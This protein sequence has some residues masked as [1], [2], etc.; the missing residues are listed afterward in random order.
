MKKF[1]LLTVV[2][3]IAGLSGLAFAFGPGPGD[4]DMRQGHGGGRYRDAMFEQALNLTEEQI[5]SVKQIRQDY[6]EQLRS[7]NDPA[8][9]GALMGLDPSDPAYSEQVEEIAKIRAAT[10]EEEI[11]LRAEKHAKIFAV[12]D[13][14]QREQFK[15]L[16]LQRKQ[17][18]H[19]RLG[20]IE[21][22]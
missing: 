2:L 11:K 22:E 16:Q 6:R 4:C 7:I 1:T 12:L 19:A 8:G 14:G 5:A 10:V 13:E 20:G 18:K 21:Q 17:F 3:T 9:R 15:Q